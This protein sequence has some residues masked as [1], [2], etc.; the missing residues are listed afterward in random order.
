VSLF[1]FEIDPQKVLG[2]PASASLAEIREAY[3]Q[4]AKRYHPDAGG[5][6]WA[7]RIIVQAYEML[8]QARVLRATQMEQAAERPAPAPAPRPK[9]DRGSES[10][11]AGIHDKNVPPERLVALELLCVR[12]LWEEADYLWIAQRAPDE[13]RF[14][15]CNLN[16][17]WPDPEVPRHGQAQPASPGTVAALQDIFDQMMIATRAVNSRARADDDR[18]EAWLTYSNFDRAWKSVNTVHGL[19][20]A[21]GLGLRQWSRDVFIARPTRT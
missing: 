19:L 7:F 21:R 2:I 15:S 6:E 13:D 14:L 5:E 3:R 18:F 17:L 8:S 20:R 11:H 12:Y 4:K 1:S 16:L 9:V 10:V